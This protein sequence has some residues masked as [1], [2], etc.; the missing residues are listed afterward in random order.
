MKKLKIKHINKYSLLI[1]VATALGYLFSFVQYQLIKERVIDPYNSVVSYKVLLAL[2]IGNIGL[3]ILFYKRIINTLFMFVQ[4]ILLLLM[5]T[6]TNNNLSITVIL[7]PVYLFA[8]GYFL[9]KPINIL[10]SL[11]A[12]LSILC[13]QQSISLDNIKTPTINLNEFIMLCFLFLL[14]LIMNYIVSSITELYEDLSNQIIKQKNTIINLIEANVGI[15]KYAL[16]KKEEFENAERFRITRDIHDTIGYV[17]TN[18]I[19]LLQACSYYVPKRMKKVHTFLEDALANA[20]NG[21]NETRS[22]LRKLHNFDRINGA[23]E[24]MRIIEIFKESCGIEV[25]CNFGNTS[26]SWGHSLDYV[27]YRII[28]EGLVN[29][30]KHGMAT[31][32]MITFWQND[33]EILLNISDNGKGVQDEEMKKG[34]GISG[35]EE[36]L[37]RFKGTLIAESMPHGFSLHITVPR[38]SIQNEG[39]NEDYQSYAC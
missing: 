36:R 17:M 25:T 33:N 35:M 38:N 9:K 22:I 23:Q 7:S 6:M 15:Q 4:L 31:M 5:I 2:S 19:M 18:N 39:N 8:A 28:Q 32:V 29:S 1:A 12:A 37:N 13:F 16:N 14:I 24:I 21:L 34:I 27:F 20:K 10:F 30:V 11:F 26:G 3:L